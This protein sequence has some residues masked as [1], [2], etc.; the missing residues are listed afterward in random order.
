MLENS[1]LGSLK[2]CE[3]FSEGRVRASAFPQPF[4]WGHGGL[5]R[6]S[7]CDGDG[8]KPL[9][10]FWTPG[11]LLGQP[12]PPPATSDWLGCGRSSD[13]SPRK[14]FP[15]ERVWTPYP[16]LL[17][18][19]RERVKGRRAGSGA[20]GDALG[21]P[22]RAGVRLRSRSALPA[23]ARRGEGRNGRR[24]LHWTLQTPPS[25]S[26]PA[27]TS[28]ARGPPPGPDALSFEKAPRC[29]NRGQRSFLQS[30]PSLFV[31]DRTR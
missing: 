31:A 15:F 19:S 14:G 26:P 9:K 16:S 20:G 25:S 18:S 27:S 23:L 28:D 22:P 24:R 7:A 30:R 8:P 3:G 12:P 17:F 29:R 11:F 1:H 4:V 21:P 10:A 6:G 2:C 5:F 13:F